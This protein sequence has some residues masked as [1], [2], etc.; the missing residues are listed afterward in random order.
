M[1]TNI[2]VE[3]LNPHP[4]NPRKDLGDLTELA[5]SIKARGVMQ[6]LTVVPYLGEVTGQPIEGVYRV[7]IGHRRLAAAK[8]AGLTELPCVISEMDHRDQV[9]T[10]LLE[11]MQRSDL[12][13]YEQAQGF[14]MMLDL[15]ET[16][17][18]IAE[19]TGL[20]ETTI[21][22]R[23]KLTELDQKKF[24]ASL[25]RGGTLMDYAELEK[26]KDPELRSQVLDFIGT[27]NFKWKLEQAIEEEAV[28]EGKEKLR[29]FLNEFA[30]EIPEAIPG[31]AYVTSFYKFKCNM[32][33]APR[34]AG[35]R[36][37]YYLMSRYDATLYVEKLKTEAEVEEDPK[38][39]ATRLRYEKLCDLTKKAYEMRK[40]FILN[41]KGAKKYAD[42]I[43]AF[44]L[45]AILVGGYYSGIDGLAR[46]LGI[47]E[48]EN[49]NIVEV[50][51][52][53]HQSIQDEY[54]KNPE[55]VTLA[56]AYGRFSDSG[57]NKY[58]NYRSWEDNLSH[59]ENDSLDVLY[60][61]LIS[62]GYEMSDEERQ[63]QDGTHE[64][65][66]NPA[67][68]SETNEMLC[69]DGFPCD[70][71]I[72]DDGGGCGYDSDDPDEDYCV[73]GNKRIRRSDEE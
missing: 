39:K 26:I 36:K 70:D 15:G 52:S 23:V 63:L 17:A 72:Y 64:L 25:K 56:A 71:C 14:Q 41:F 45:E 35:E 20:S 69:D 10:M 11:N 40:D 19:K 42:E 34:D 54:F 9:A 29:T 60:S 37:Y 28:P 50:R 24:A 55:A 30:T 53:L 58:F 43:H 27:N 59:Q 5:E 1:I 13:V 2:S 32:K 38:K 3:R 4:D 31:A 12:T 67:E 73:D 6:N 61:A 68:E 51:R 49:G 48:S 33:E 18:T 21:R 44:A 47:K 22:R 65:F 57:E 16:A 7:V 8:L 62:L 66:E 46:S